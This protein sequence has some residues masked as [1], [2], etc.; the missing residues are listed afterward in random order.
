MND[1]QSGRARAR[2]SAVAMVLHWAIALCLAFAIAIGLR[3]EEPLTPDTFALYQLHK[4]L[5]IL[6]LALILVRIAWRWKKPPPPLPA[7]LS[8]MER[9]GAHGV[10]L[11]FYVIL[12]GLP[13]TG[14][15][16]VSA[17]DRPIPTVLFGL[18][19]FPDVPGMPAVGEPARAALYDASQQ[20]HHWL[21]KLTYVAVVLHVAGALKHQFLDRTD[22]FGRM[23]PLAPRWLGLGLLASVALLGA[24]FLAGDRL[25]LRRTVSAETA[26]PAAPVVASAALPVDEQAVEAGEGV[27][28]E[29][30]EADE[31]ADPTAP[32]EPA[33]W[34]V[35]RGA[36]SVRFSTSYAGMPIDGAFGQWNADIRF[37]PEALDRSRVEV[38]IGLA[39]VTSSNPDVQ[40]MLPGS[41]FFAADRWPRATFSADRFTAL[42][43]DRYR[44]SGNLSLRGRTRPQRLDFTLRIAGDT[45]RVSAT[46]TVDR[47]V[48]QVG[49]GDWANTAELAAGVPVQIELVARRAAAP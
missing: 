12:L 19:P 2:Y 14:W 45:A 6:I 46:A 32:P 18:I 36:S 8:R 30:A 33:V 34:R 7:N 23:L 38:S 49:Q 10:H 29:P 1:S 48:F 39:S 11:A 28:E 16:L 37:D 21:V 42:G 17:S 5:G 13:L 25:E 27:E 24:S 4:S 22:H 41:D 31:P 40:G 35:Q 20:G 44:A 9:L 3:L 15:L 43:G 47:T 26:E